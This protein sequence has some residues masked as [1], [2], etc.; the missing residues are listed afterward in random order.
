MDEMEMCEEAGVF[1][2]GKVG[3]D[4]RMRALADSNKAS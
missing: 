3:V 4:G 1:E 2:G